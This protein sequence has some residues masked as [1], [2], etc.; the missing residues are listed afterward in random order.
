MGLEMID[1]EVSPRIN[2]LLIETGVTLASLSTL[3]SSL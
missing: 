3:A 2:R 1:M